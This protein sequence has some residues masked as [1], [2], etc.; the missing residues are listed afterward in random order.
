MGMW[1][2]K[3]EVNASYNMGTVRDLPEKILRKMPQAQDAVDEFYT[4]LRALV[5]GYRAG[6]QMV[7]GQNGKK[8]LKKS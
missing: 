8:L 2:P 5:D 6:K 7:C 3:T 1:Y 4:N